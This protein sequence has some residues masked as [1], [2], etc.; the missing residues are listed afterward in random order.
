MDGIP[1]EQDRASGRALTRALDWPRYSPE[2]IECAG[3]DGGMQF[4]ARFGHIRLV[5][6]VQR[7]PKAGQECVRE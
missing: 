7:R 3:A 6:L 2:F 5:L 1:G 4:S